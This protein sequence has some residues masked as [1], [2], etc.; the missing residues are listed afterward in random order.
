MGRPFALGLFG[1]PR[2]TQ[3][4]LERRQLTLR[5]GD[6]LVTGSV[7]RRSDLCPRAVSAYLAT[8]CC[9]FLPF[10]V[11]VPFTDGPAK[12][13]LPLGIHWRYRDDRWLR[14]AGMPCGVHRW[15]SSPAPARSA[16][17]A[18]CL[19][20]C[21]PGRLLSAAAKV[22]LLGTLRAAPGWSVP[23]TASTLPPPGWPRPASFRSG[24]PRLSW[25]VHPG[26]GRPLH[27]APVFPPAALARLGPRSCSPSL[28]SFSSRFVRSVSP[29]SSL[30][31]RHPSPV[32]AFSSSAILASHFVWGLACCCFRRSCRCRRSSR[33]AAPTAAPLPLVRVLLYS[34]AGRLFS[35]QQQLLYFFLCTPGR[36]VGTKTL[37]VGMTRF[38]QILALLSY[39]SP[40][41]T[42]LWNR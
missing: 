23:P 10:G 22:S 20:L 42:C 21:L 41:A 35:E 40:L 11:C 16:R 13:S 24:A 3:S 2:R 14:P 31:S 18:P 36:C 26:D 34:L 39:C 33:R 29:R 32:V 17:P 30:F 4:S 8:A 5:S 15:R 28:F 7:A 19:L 1:A 6:R 37:A 25:A 9:F 38:F 27:G 12:R